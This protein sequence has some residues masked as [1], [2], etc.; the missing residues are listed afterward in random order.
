MKILFFYNLFCS[1]RKEPVFRLS[2]VG[3]D[4]VAALI[5]IGLGMLGF[6]TTYLGVVDL[7]SEYLKPVNEAIEEYREVSERYNFMSEQV[8]DVEV[9][10]EELL[11]LNKKLNKIKVKK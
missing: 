5:V 3:P 1:K 7:I 11:K 2:K 10:K 9:S 4:Q 6:V 8:R